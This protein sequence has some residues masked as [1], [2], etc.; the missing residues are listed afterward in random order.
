MLNKNIQ[1]YK[2]KIKHFQVFSDIEIS[3]IVNALFP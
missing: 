2:V 1:Y 3:E